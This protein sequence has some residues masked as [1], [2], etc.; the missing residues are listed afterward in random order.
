MLLERLANPNA[1]SGNR[2]TALHLAALVAKLF[3]AKAALTARANNHA[4][5]LFGQTSFHL[6]AAAARSNAE[7]FQHLLEAGANP[8]A[9]DQISIAR[10]WKNTNF[11]YTMFGFWRIHNYPIPFPSI[12]NFL[13]GS[14][15]FDMSRSSK[16]SFPSKISMFSNWFINTI[17]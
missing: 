5:D 6:A 12:S 1:A 3:I 10:C 9:H 16:T 7:I 2:R 4:Q 14:C 17:H 8:L 13:F 11:T 15:P